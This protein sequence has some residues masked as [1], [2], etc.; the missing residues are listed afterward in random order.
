MTI[1]EFLERL[2]AL[3]DGWYISAGRIRRTP[4]NHPPQC[5]ISALVGE[6]AMRWLEAAEALGLSI[7]D[8]ERIVVAADG[9]D[10]GVDF[11]VTLRAQLLAA[12]VNRRM[13]ETPPI[14]DPQ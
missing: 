12:T 2:A 9:D 3:D 14:A 10:D 7:G 8:R 1:P 5:P 4:N 11:D 13:R 6:P